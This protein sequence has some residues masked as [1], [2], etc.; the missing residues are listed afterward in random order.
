MG[1][2]THNYPAPLSAQGPS[3]PQV[4]TPIIRLIPTEATFILTQLRQL[5]LEPFGVNR[6][7]NA[8]WNLNWNLDQNLAIYP[9]Q[10]GNFYNGLGIIVKERHQSPTSMAQKHTPDT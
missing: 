1:Y 8:Y 4:P 7:S 2:Y 5:T 10:E 3:T 6:H 9:E